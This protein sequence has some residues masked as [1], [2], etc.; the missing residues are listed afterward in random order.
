MNEF[1][2]EQS[3]RSARSTWY[4]RLAHELSEKQKAD[5]DE[6]LADDTISASTISL[7]LTRWGLNVSGQAIG[8][9]RRRYCV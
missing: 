2:E 5:L 7:V 3:K 8:N 9:Y 4:D 1:R 6:A